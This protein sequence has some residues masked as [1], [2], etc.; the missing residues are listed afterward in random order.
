[1]P[2]S[3]EPVL[4]PWARAATGAASVTATNASATTV[5]ESFIVYPPL[6]SAFRAAATTVP[7]AC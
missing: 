6:P 7:A 2:G 4:K 3:V 5:R 1:V